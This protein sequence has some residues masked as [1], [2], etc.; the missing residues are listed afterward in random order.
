MFSLLVRSSS[1]ASCSVPKELTVALVALEMPPMGRDCDEVF[2][3]ELVIVAFTGADL[4]SGG[5]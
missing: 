4:P 3:D 2:K 1:I 5:T